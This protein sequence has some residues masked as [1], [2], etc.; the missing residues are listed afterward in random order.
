MNSVMLGK[1]S[2]RLGIRAKI[3]PT[4]A[5]GRGRHRLAV[6]VLMCLAIAT[7]STGLTTVRASAISCQPGRVLIASYDNSFRWDG[8]VFTYAQWDGSVRLYEDLDSGCFV[9]SVLVDFNGPS[10]GGTLRLSGSTIGVY[11]SVQYPQPYDTHPDHDLNPDAYGD[12]VS[13]NPDGYFQLYYAHVHFDVNTR[14]ADEYFIG[15]NTPLPVVVTS[16]HASFQLP[17]ELVGQTV[18]AQLHVYP[19]LCQCKATAIAIPGQTPPPP[20]PSPPPSG[21]AWSVYVHA[22]ED[23]WQLFESPS[24]VSDYQAGNNLLF[25]IVTAGDAGMSPSYWQAR[26]EATMASVQ[27][28][29]GPQTEIAKS[30]PFC[31]STPAVCH[32]VWQRSYGQTIS[33]FMRLPDGNEDGFGWLS[34]GFVSLAKLRDG[35]ILSLTAVDGSTTYGSWQDLYLTVS[36]IVSTYAPYDS[37]T[38]INAPD[39][40]RTRQSFEGQNCRTCSDHS[41]HLAVA[42]LIRTISIERGAPWA[43]QWFIDYPIGW[44]DSRYPANLNS[45][46]YTIKRDLFMAYN[47]RF[48]A[49]TGIDAYANQKVF[50]ENCFQRNY[51]RTA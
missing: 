50:W 3:P 45:T 23:D 1:E 31:H 35:L 25:I 2:G 47:E 42:D 19:N 38:T 51:V 43:R 26:E 6:V 40:D 11:Y 34:T 20:P 18:Y 16:V 7:I 41:D 39:F 5:F 33:I 32:N 49:L 48:R 37:T 28:V 8:D 13:V 15:V 27:Y 21:P 36:A 17:L 44:A 10:S 46:G 30:V 22:H 9:V 14:G 24:S 12:A 4:R 29:T